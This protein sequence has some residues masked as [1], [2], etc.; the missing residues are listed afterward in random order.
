MVRH[1]LTAILFIISMSMVTVMPCIITEVTVT[2]PLKLK[3]SCSGANLTAIPRLEGSENIITLIASGN[4]I[5]SLGERSFLGYENVELIDLQRNMIERIDGNTFRL[6]QSLKHVYLSGNK[7]KYMSKDLFSNCS[8]MRKL[9]VSHNNFSG[10]KRDYPFLASS[11]LT[12]LD[13]SQSKLE[14]LP[15]KFFSDMQQLEYIYLNKNNLTSLNKLA[16]EP[17]RNLKLV[18][19]DENPWKCTCELR[20]TVLLFKELAI[21]I[22]PSE[23]VC[24]MGIEKMNITF[25]VQNNSCLSQDTVVRTIDAPVRTEKSSTDR[26]SKKIVA[27]DLIGTSSPKND[28]KTVTLENGTS[29]ENI[30]TAHE[31]LLQKFNETKEMAIKNRKEIDHLKALVTKQNNYVILISFLL[32][33]VVII[34]TIYFYQLMKDKRSEKSKLKSKGR[35]EKYEHSQESSSENINTSNENTKKGAKEDTPLT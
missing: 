1:I 25:I 22:R 11:T 21:D 5:A 27:G 9:D 15:A 26:Y 33:L 2:G 7:L 16:F 23:I 32:V 30:K 24:S 13:L 34:I 14:N 19:L 12:W 35:S 31:L 17:L 4:S 8:S 29:E 20:D 18:F 3:A 6:L 10:V 28:D